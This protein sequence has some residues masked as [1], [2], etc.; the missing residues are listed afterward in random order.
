MRRS[1]SNCSSPPARSTI[2]SRPC[3]PSSACRR[4][5][6]QRNWVGHPPN[7]GSRRRSARVRRFLGSVRDITE[8]GGVAMPLYMD[9][10]TVDGGVAIDDVVKAHQADLQTQ[11]AYDVRYLRYW[12]D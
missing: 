2:T 4:V 6:K 3:W 1:T 7:L 10:H 8:P 9:V 5:A 12:V 11:A